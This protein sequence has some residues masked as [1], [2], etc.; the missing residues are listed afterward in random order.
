M[1][2]RTWVNPCLSA[3]RNY[4]RAHLLPQN[5]PRVFDS[6]IAE[7]IP[8]QLAPS[9]GKTACWIAVS[10]V[11]SSSS[12]NIHR[13]KRPDRTYRRRSVHSRSNLSHI[14]GDATESTINEAVN[15]LLHVATRPVNNFVSR[16]LRQSTNSSVDNFFMWRQSSRQLCQSTTSSC[17]GKAVDNFVSRQLR[18]VAEFRA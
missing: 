16:Q 17:G 2:G 14:A 11:Q 6:G 13:Q 8:R 9:V 4:Q 3:V 15:K 10:A 12:S 7:D 5:L 18:H 1:R